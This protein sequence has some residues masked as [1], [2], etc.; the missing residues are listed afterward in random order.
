MPNNEKEEILEK[1]K[2]QGFEYE[3]RYKQC[4]QAVLAPL[5]D[6]FDIIDDKII[7]SAHA[8]AGG[9]ARCGDGTC[10]ALAGAMMALSCKWGRE[11]KYFDH[12]V[13]RDY[14]EEIAKELHDK[15]IEEYGSV[16]C[17]KVHEKIFGRTYDLWDPKE[18][19]E[20]EDA[21]AHK[22][23]C[24]EVVGK[25]AKWT[26]SFL[27]EEGVPLKKPEEWP[28]PPGYRPSS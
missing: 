4:S 7:K 2:S 23:K 22:D 17:N 5:Q 9:T 24:P 25:V 13:E 18:Y 10:G 20:F 14:P 21:G 16:I 15:F 1:I 8:F 27:L 3:K 12:G 28:T 19:K 11:R 26:A 6:F